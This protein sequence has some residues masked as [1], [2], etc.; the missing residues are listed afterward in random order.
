MVCKKEHV[1]VGPKRKSAYMKIPHS[2]SLTILLRELGRQWVTLDDS[3]VDTSVMKLE[4]AISDVSSQ[5]NC[6][7]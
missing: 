6:A 5:A 4:N 3:Q 2:I 7:P 1:A